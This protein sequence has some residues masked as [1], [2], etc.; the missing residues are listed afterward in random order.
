MNTEQQQIIVVHA[1][2]T[3]IQR[4]SQ[5][6]MILNSQYNTSRLKHLPHA[7]STH[8]EIPYYAFHFIHE[9]QSQAVMGV[10]LLKH[11]VRQVHMPPQEQRL[12]QFDNVAALKNSNTVVHM[13]YKRFPKSAGNSYR[14]VRKFHL[15]G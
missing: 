8:S 9:Y 10:I 12:T 15:Q 4:P 13:Q 7:K 14:R 3:D 5:Q 1:P 2:V 6:D 11:S